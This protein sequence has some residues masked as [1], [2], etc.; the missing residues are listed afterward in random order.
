[1]KI[2][3]VKQPDGSIVDI[4]IGRGSDGTSVSITSIK[5]NPDDDGIN[6]IYFSDGSVLQVKNGS[7]GADG[8]K[9]DT[10]DPG[11]A[12]KDGVSATHTWNGTTLSVTSA[13][14]TSSADLKGEKGATGNDGA[15][16]T[17]NISSTGIIS[18]TND[19]GLTNPTSVNI[20]D[21]VLAA[22]PTWEGGSY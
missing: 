20:V 12:G 19:K 18:W 9:G 5:E 2:M 4:P 14:G 17:P 13:S 6:E 22:L 11:S 3:R 15:T 10:G 7:K 21:S 16:F 8:G 1:M